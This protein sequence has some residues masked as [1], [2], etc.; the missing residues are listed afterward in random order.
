ERLRRIME[1]M[2]DGLVIID[3]RGVIETFNLAAEKIFGYKASEVVG[4]PVNILMAED[5][6]ES[7]QGHVNAFLETGVGQVIGGGREVEGRRKDGSVFPL[8]LALSALRIADQRLF[9]GV[10]RDIS[11]RKAAEE[12]LR[13]LATRDH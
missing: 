6:G 13:F 4:A 10:L 2:V 11:E 12:R 9:I 7:H 5:D 8:D 1:T 3:E